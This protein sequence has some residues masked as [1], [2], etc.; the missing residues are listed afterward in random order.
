[1]GHASKIPVTEAT[2]M[3][4]RYVT[5]LVLALTT[6]SAPALAQDLGVRS[7]GVRGG[8]NVNPD[9]FSF[10]AHVDAG[11]LSPRLRF[12][13]SFELGIGNGVTLAAASFDVHYLFSERGWRP[14]AGGGL[15]INFVDV[16]RGF[17]ASRGLDIE[18]VLNLVGGVEW[19]RPR[20][21]SRAFRRYLLEMRIGMGKTPDLRIVA[22][23]SF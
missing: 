20:E 18:P 2:P 12:Q 13:P 6:T 19:G 10:G 21:N 3:I 9:Q 17:G 7:Y 14:Y 4:V 16:N 1:M 5:L 15:G 11:T 22:G 8:I 23:Y